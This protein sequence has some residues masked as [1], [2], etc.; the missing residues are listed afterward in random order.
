M[1]DRLAGVAAALVGGSL[2]A[3]AVAEYV[4][5]APTP[6]P[7]DP[8]ATGVVVAGS[9]L[10]LIAAGVI[11]IANRV[12]AV[13]LRTGTAVAVAVLALA[14]LAPDVLRFGGVFWLGLVGAVL[15]TAGGVATLRIAW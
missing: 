7:L 8:F 12:D 11:A 5:G 3:V 1:D 13:S 4:S 2:T 15:V 10:V 9:G 6:P 14:V